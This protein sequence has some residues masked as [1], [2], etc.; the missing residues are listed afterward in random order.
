MRG[1]T[2]VGICGVRTHAHAVG[3]QL[4][5]LPGPPSSAPRARADAG[6]ARR[7]ARGTT[8]ASAMV[9]G[10][11]GTKLKGIFWGSNSQPGK[12]YYGRKDDTPWNHD[13]CH[14]ALIESEHD[15]SHDYGLRLRP[16]EM[17]IAAN[18]HDIFLS[19]DD[20]ELETGS[21]IH[22][23]LRRMG[24]IVYSVEGEQV[25]KITDAGVRDLRPMHVKN[26]KLEETIDRKEDINRT[27][28][29]SCSAVCVIVTRHPSPGT[30]LLSDSMAEDI[31]AAQ[32][33]LK[34]V[35]LLACN[36][37]VYD[38]IVTKGFSRQLSEQLQG[39][40]SGNFKFQAVVNLSVL[41]N[42]ARITES[43]LQVCQQ[44]ILKA[45]EKNLR[46]VPGGLYRGSFSGLGRPG[47]NSK[48]VE[49]CKLF[50]DGEM[51]GLIRGQD[52]MG[53]AADFSQTRAAGFSRMNTSTDGILGPDQI[54]DDTGSEGRPA[55]SDS[56]LR[57]GSLATP[58]MLSS[59]C[60][61]SRVLTHPDSESDGSGFVPPRARRDAAPNTL[62]SAVL[63][64]TLDGR[65]RVRAKD[66]LQLMD[67]LEP[68]ERRKFVT[69][70]SR[71][72]TAAG[73]L[74][75]GQAGLA[76]GRV[77][78]P[79]LIREHV[80]G[81]D[82]GAQ[83]PVYQEGYIRPASRQGS[84]GAGNNSR[85][86]FQRVVSADYIPNVAHGPTPS[87]Y[88]G[89]SSPSKMISTEGM[90]SFYGIHSIYRD[91]FPHM[92]NT[93]YLSRTNSIY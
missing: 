88:W 17:H 3:G 91:H 62:M 40:I 10:Y 50:F 44:R 2:G 49:D 63:S 47:C 69:E 51:P 87:L 52:L 72:Q 57:R 78:T 70:I 76:G 6:P 18:K 11:M 15:L 1:K 74:R 36:K 41:E 89:P 93:F 84:Q 85:L 90:L 60:R 32:N 14:K 71:P 19:Y 34:K 48:V 31:A 66:V 59:S 29:Q 43:E 65:A 21:Q 73:N 68:D 12:F 67:R 8:P 16:S 33:N 30:Q 26:L 7:A 9:R 4:R 64:A 79:S 37:T 75:P 83:R 77:E 38:S 13:L 46:I 35:V 86:G 92:E 20:E 23:W 81:E 58:S 61:S 24:Y 28:V 5:A 54:F 27:A 39:R 82:A 45:L 53:P 22:A 25:T 55:T 80:L 56:I 42:R